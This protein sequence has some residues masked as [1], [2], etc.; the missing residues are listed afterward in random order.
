MGL[1]FHFSSK[2]I[3]HVARLS[4]YGCKSEQT[5]S[6]KT[7]RTQHPQH[8]DRLVLPT[9]SIYV[10]MSWTFFLLKSNTSN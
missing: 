9:L 6:L 3:V 5:M 7:K 8:R 1:L 4:M 2:D 10:S